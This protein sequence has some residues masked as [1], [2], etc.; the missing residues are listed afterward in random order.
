MKHTCKL[1]PQELALPTCSDCLRIKN[2]A[3]DF[4]SQSLELYELISPTADEIQSAR[5]L[6]NDTNHDELIDMMLIPADG[7]PGYM[8]KLN[9]ALEVLGDRENEIEEDVIDEMI[10]RQTP[11]RD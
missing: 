6:Y 9:T 5:Q 11:P 8:Q 7:D 3:Q 2:I 1:Y 4:A 10:E